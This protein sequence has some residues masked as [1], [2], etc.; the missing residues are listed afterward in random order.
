MEEFELKNRANALICYNKYWRCE[1]YSCPLFTHCS[2]GVL[3]QITDYEIELL[4]KKKVN[5]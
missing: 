4:F 1:D 3:E 5:D 2:A